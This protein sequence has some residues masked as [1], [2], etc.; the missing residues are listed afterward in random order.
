MRKKEIDFVVTW[1][2]GAD[3]VWRNEKRNWEQKIT[4]ASDDR[5]ERYRD[6]GL[7]RYWFRGVERCA[8]WVRRVFF[9]SAGQVPDWMNRDCKKLCIVN[10]K[11]YIPRQ[12]LPTFNSNTIEMNF[13][14]IKGLSEHFVYFNDDI[15]L[16]RR[17]SP[18]F[19]FRDGKPVDMLALQPVV[20]NESDDT[21]PYIYLNNA[22]V[23]ARHFTK[24]KDIGKYFY[25]G[26]PPIHF[27]YNLLEMAFPRFTGFY[28]AHGPSPML[29]SV[30]EFLWRKESEILDQTS[31]HKF[32]D[33]GDVNQ[34]LVREWNK[35]SGNFVPSNLD[36]DLCYV[37][38][39][40]DNTRVADAVRQRKRSVICIN[41]AYTGISFERTKRQL[42]AAFAS[43]FPEKSMFE[44]NHS[45]L[46]GG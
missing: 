26:Y 43:V 41:D 39:T 8:P 23:L 14:R 11:D 18:E 17:V 20:A 29:K 33:R 31:L 45:S 40:T 16:L 10:H 25:P 30:Y 15:F 42:K 12:Y 38:L 21:M 22:M 2:D 19:F 9:V 7:L 34:Y 28:T 24:R 3:P 6:F 32:R 4:G 27:V 35:L 44:R 36:R 46:L 5:E 37:N 13:H 1:V